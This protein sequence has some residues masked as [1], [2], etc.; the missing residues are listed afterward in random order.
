MT[1]MAP[2][3]AAAVYLNSTAIFVGL[4]ASSLA[5]FNASWMRS[6]ATESY[7]SAISKKLPLLDLAPDF[8]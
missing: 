4:S 3:K 8:S 7:R 5:S 1:P 6:P 2:S